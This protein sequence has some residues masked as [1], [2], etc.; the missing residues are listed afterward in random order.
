V[1]AD[2]A[3]RTRHSH[4]VDQRYDATVLVIRVGARRVPD[5]EYGVGEVESAEVSVQVPQKADIDGDVT[6]AAVL[7]P[8]INLAGFEDHK[9]GG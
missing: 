2:S 3:R 1:L 6:L 8:G 9:D 4:V 7:A 5:G